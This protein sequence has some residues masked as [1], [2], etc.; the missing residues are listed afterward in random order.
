MSHTT[1]TMEEELSGDY[2]WAA[3]MS[4]SMIQGLRQRLPYGPDFKLRLVEALGA[5]APEID[6]ETRFQT[7]ETAL[8]QEFCSRL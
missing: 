3:E 2:C 8:E 1:K 6:R 7:V 5:L 4:R